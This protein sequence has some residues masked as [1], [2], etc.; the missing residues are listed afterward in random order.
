MTT[1]T[2]T[3][4]SPHWHVLG[5]T[6]QMTTETNQ[7]QHARIGK[8]RHHHGHLS[9]PKNPPRTWKQERRE[10]RDN[11]FC[12]FVPSQQ[13]DRTGNASSPSHHTTPTT[14]QMRHGPH[15]DGGFWVNHH[16]HAS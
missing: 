15:A 3:T 1:T 8:G 6:Q 16:R 4:Q 14:T 9:Q 5:K 2:H 12:H 10:R 13:T 11:R 7:V